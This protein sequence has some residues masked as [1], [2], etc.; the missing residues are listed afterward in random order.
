MLHLTPARMKRIAILN[1]IEVDL[2]SSRIVIS[3]FASSS[4]LFQ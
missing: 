4:I 2:Y 3:E 1:E